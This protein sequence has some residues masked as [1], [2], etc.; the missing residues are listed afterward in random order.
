MV[1]TLLIIVFFVVISSINLVE[2]LKQTLRHELVHVFDHCRA[3]IDSQNC[4]QIGC[5]E[6]RAASLSGE[7]NF[8][9]EVMRLNVT[10]TIRKK[11]QVCVKRRA[12]QSLKMHPHCRDKAEEIIDTIFPVC[13]NDLEPYGHHPKK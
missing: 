10:T 11:Q 5:S 2:R 9:R 12:V 7:C 4:Y 6:I 8:S 1:I 13:W 3:N